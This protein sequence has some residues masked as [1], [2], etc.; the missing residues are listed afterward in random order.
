MKKEFGFKQIGSISSSKDF[1]EQAKKRLMQRICQTE[2]S[3]LENILYDFRKIKPKNFFYLLSKERLLNKIQQPFIFPLWLNKFFLNKKFISWAT[4]VCIILISIFSFAVSTPQTV[5][6]TNSVY[7]VITKGNPIIKQLGQDWEM[8]QQLQE[9]KIGDTIQTD[10]DDIVEVHFFD[11]SV[12]RLAYNSE[13]TITDFFKEKSRE[14]VELNLNEGR[15]WSKV[16]QAASNTA[17]FT[18]KTHNSSVSTKNATFDIKAAKNH[19]TS[20]NVIDHLIDVKI[21]QS[22]AR[23][24]V[25]KTKV[26]E[27]YKVEVQVSD[28]KT[29]AQTAE[30]SPIENQAQDSWVT[31]NL[32]KDKVYVENIEK[33]REDKI[34]AAAGILPDSP[35]YGV[36]KGFEA[37]T[38][39]SDEDDIL[40]NLRQKF[41]E[42]VAL[43]AKGATAESD[44]ELNEFKKLFNE[45]QNTDLLKTDLETLLAELQADFTTTLPGNKNYKFKESLRKFEIQIAQNPEAV[46][47][48]KTTEK[49]FEAQDL[50]DNGEI[51]L[52]KELLVGLN[53][54][55]TVLSGTG[56]LVAEEK[57][58][59]IL[60]KTEE[61][62]ILQSLK[63]NIK[64][65]DQEEEL[66]DFVNNIQKNIVTEIDYL[67]PQQEKTNKPTIVAVKK[68][69]PQIVAQNL[70]EK[71][72]IY[73]S[74]KGQ[75]NQLF[76]ILNDISPNA[77]NLPLLTELKKLLPA[78]KQYLVTKK[79]LEITNK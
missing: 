51:E 24:V 34:I 75:K 10:Q 76:K 8:A 20:I 18:V 43:N 69:D 14:K 1:R 72:N 28:K 58:E 17:D 3:W 4:T 7:L 77:K 52:V 42:A 33:K 71:I 26:A 68:D 23:N 37:I 32:A 2:A 16:V 39:S 9:L 22:D 48:K 50:L 21:L 45:A 67:S 31:E 54:E 78:D 55:K 5:E 47:F 57:K 64:A 74:E 70:L 35:L 6:A 46:L 56:N 79:I 15:A 11:N 30:I 36:K 49:L 65:T 25:A 19:P 62:Q 61:L 27:G 60:Q 53:N 38:D 44:N 41:N 63:E 40:E 73:N 59:V 29:I 66:I 12:T 13:L